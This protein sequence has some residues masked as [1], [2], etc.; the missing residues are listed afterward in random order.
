[1]TRDKFCE[2]EGF[3]LLTYRKLHFNGLAPEERILP[4]T[5]IVDITVEAHRAWRKMIKQQPDGKAAEIVRR[6]RE[7]SQ[8][9]ALSLKSPNHPANLIKELR[10]L[11]AARAA[12]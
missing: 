8:R 5:S 3:G 10:A 1:M 12:E 4:G 6:G 9:G 11:K 7:G 2:A